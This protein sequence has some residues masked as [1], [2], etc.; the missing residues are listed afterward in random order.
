MVHLTDKIAGPAI[1]GAAVSDGQPIATVTNSQDAD[2]S[3][4]LRLKLR[5]L[6]HVT[7][8][9]V[10]DIVPVHRAPPVECAPLRPGLW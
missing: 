9:S 3:A 5:R 2:C 1:C 10:Q 6:E 8:R 4:C 7:G